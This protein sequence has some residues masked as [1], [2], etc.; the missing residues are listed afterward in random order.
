MRSKNFRI[1]P[2]QSASSP[3]VKL[4][5]EADSVTH[6]VGVNLRYYQRSH[7]C[8]S[9][10]QRKELASLSS[11]FEKM[12]SKTVAQVTSVTQTCHSHLGRA[13]KKLPAEVSMDVKM[14]SL[15][16]TSGG[17]VHGFFSGD[18]FFLVWLDRRGAVLGH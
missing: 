12:A 15:D 6:F 5:R 4:S 2:R 18:S 17:R 8:L 14:Y 9:D 13:S 7:E 11:F 16:V 3:S 1:N 10:W